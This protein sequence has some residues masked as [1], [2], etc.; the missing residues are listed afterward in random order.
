MLPTEKTQTSLLRKVFQWRMPP[1]PVV[2]NSILKNEYGVFNVKY[3]I[4]QRKSYA[5][6]KTSSKQE[7][8]IRSF[9]AVIPPIERD[10]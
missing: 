1:I 6:N 5:I 10:D 4:K 7:K 8:Q 3:L 9:T 2:K